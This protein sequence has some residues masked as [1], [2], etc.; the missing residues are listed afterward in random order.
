MTLWFIREWRAVAAS[1]LMATTGA[2]DSPRAMEVDGATA[3]ER[4]GTEAERQANL[5]PGLLLAIG[6]VESGRR[7]PITGHVAAWPWSI[8]ANGVGQTFERLA[9][10]LAATRALQGR[11]VTSV[12]VG[13]FQ[14][15]LRHHPMAF[16]GLEEAFDP[17]AN[18]AYAARFL[19]ALRARTGSWESAVAAYH[20]A[21]PE[22]GSAYRARVL[23][24]WPQ[25]N[26]PPIATGPRVARV[27]V[28]A[29]SPVT[30]RMQVWIP[31]AAG[32]AP[33]I[34]SFGPASTGLP[35]PV[36]AIKVLKP[37]S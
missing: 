31:N 2:I 12:D 32:M 30:N 17:Q 8:D 18:A 25:A 16:S 27:M 26:M 33:S 6:V 10:A 14:I 3:C 22:R 21:M 34:I 36:Q 35:T 23:A 20:S 7:D 19:S 37:A 13:C 11:G 24:S 15:N 9:D 29:P 5:P 4:A 28:W 1:L